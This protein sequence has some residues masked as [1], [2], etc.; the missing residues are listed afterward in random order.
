[1]PDMTKTPE[2]SEAVLEELL[3]DYQSPED[4]LGPDGLMKELKR[5]LIEK[6]LGA[7]LTDHLGYDKADPA[8]RGSGNN[9][10]G[11]SKKTVKSEDGA[12]ELA[13]PR[14]RNGSF[15][16]KLV[17]KGQTRI[18][19]FD[20]KI[21]SMYARGMTVREIQAHLKSL[22]GV[23]ISP[24]LVSRVTNAV[25][26]EVKAWQNRALEAC[27]PVVIFDAL[28]VKI[29]DEGFVRNKAIYLALAIAADGRRDI[30][31]IWVEQNEGAKFWLKVMNELKNRGINDILIAV[32]DG[33]K[34]FPEA[35]N[36]AFPQTTVQTCIVHLVR[37]SLNYC[38]YKDRKIVAADLKA[39]YRAETVDAAKERL[40]E[41]DAKWGKQYPS[42]AQSWRN[43][44]DHVIPFFAFPQDIRR[45][46]YTTNA[47]ESLNASIRK[48]IKTRGSFPNDDA[49]IKLIYLAIQN[50]G[51][52]ANAGVWGWKTALNQFAIVFEE[53]MPNQI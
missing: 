49:A 51:Q 28:R 45:I 29:R 42:I 23:E 1:M 46:I 39:V 10:N 16:P 50:A 8:G 25:L 26:E 24:D 31:G 38:S 2:I 30:L 15:E 18:D 32:V 9:R 35:I 41:F 40:D 5:R 22:Y 14:D 13:V 4:L 12:V 36:A 48:I 11:A 33:L 44:W 6:A 21:I 19:G 53:R 3:K 20:D 27:Y 17:K 34:G 7:E 47:I 37:H 52:L 43:N